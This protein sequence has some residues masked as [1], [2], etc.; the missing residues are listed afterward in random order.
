METL[1]DV[2]RKRGSQFCV[3]SEKRNAKGK[4]KNLGCSSSKA[5]ARK[6]LAQ[7]EY[8]KRKKR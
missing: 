3:L 7:V 5:Q 1:E 8:F 4:R 6:R 2:I